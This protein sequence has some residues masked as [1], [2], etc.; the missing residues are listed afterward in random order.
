MQE[1]QS[2]TEPL[3]ERDPFSAEEEEKTSPYYFE[4]G[5]EGKEIGTVYQMP[6]GSYEWIYELDMKKNNSILRVVLITIGASMIPI[7]LMILFLF[8]RDG[9]DPTVALVT[10]LC[11]LAVIVI[12]LA[13]YWF[14][15]T[16][17]RWSYYMV[18]R[19]DE[20]GISFRQV[21]EQYEKTET[22]G[23]VLALLGAA[24]GNAGAASAGL[25]MTSNT[26]RSEFRNVKT[27]TLNRF[28]N[29][30]NVISPFLVNMVYVS[31]K[32]YDFVLDYIVSHCPDASFHS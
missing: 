14:L 10:G 15:G 11:F 20:E 12:S 26:A 19:M 3:R 23:R 30:I 5:E 21:R 27:I 24:G 18:Y 32:Y 6:D 4:D 7:A 8:F 1:A 16:R 9:F 13:C 29:L 17:Y 22:M 31:D 28:N 25:R 2:Q